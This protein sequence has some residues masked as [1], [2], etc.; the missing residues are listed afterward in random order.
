VQYGLRGSAS[1]NI[2]GSEDRGGDTSSRKN[3]ICEPLCLMEQ[4]FFFGGAE[5]FG[6][7]RP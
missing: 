6:G 1:G 3:D 2:S 4:G 7:T 5:N